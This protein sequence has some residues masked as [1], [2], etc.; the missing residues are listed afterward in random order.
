MY[1]EFVLF[2][3]TSEELS[4]GLDLSF[5]LGMYPREWVVVV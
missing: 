4:E 5:V 2:F 1:S 3:R